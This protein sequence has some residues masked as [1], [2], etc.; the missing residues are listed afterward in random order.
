MDEEGKYQH[1]VDN[2]EEIPIINR[3]DQY[4]S[5]ND[6]IVEKPRWTVAGKKRGRPSGKGENAKEWLDAEIYLLIELWEKK[7]VL[8]NTKHLMYYNKE[9]RDNA[10]RDI[11]KGLLAN[12]SVATI[13]QITDKMTNLKCY[14]GSQK[15]NMENMKMNG[16]DKNY[17]SPWK[18]FSNLQFLNGHFLQ[19][20]PTVRRRYVVN[21]HHQHMINKQLG[22]K[23]M[24]IEN[25][26]HHS[27]PPPPP[28][29]FPYEATAS[30]KVTIVDPY[31]IHTPK[32]SMVDP[33]MK[34]YLSPLGKSYI[35]GENGYWINEGPPPEKQ[36]VNM[37]QREPTPP[38]NGTVT[39]NLNSPTGDENVKIKSE[40]DC[41]CELMCKMLNQ[42]PESE[43]KA[44]LRLEMQQ[45]VISLRY[46]S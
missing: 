18:F 16:G 5:T 21:H 38:V 31:I 11:Q 9:E 17:S 2:G 29:Q 45:K 32:A 4:P 35:H 15:R 10:I 22:E 24:K 42:I 19:R 41:F 26:N 39:K 34:T 14:Y 43:E 33:Y 27:P 44:M 12:N 36:P 40:D 7:E 3:S 8:Y 1:Y 25:G 23:S 28:P 30:S 46:R 6:S 20:T 37:P 13:E